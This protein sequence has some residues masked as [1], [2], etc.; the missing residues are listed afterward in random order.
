MRFLD[1]TEILACI[2]PIPDAGAFP[3]SNPGNGAQS[4]FDERFALESLF[5][6][7]PPSSFLID[8]FAY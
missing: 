2:E 6:F 5:E 3:G 4:M 8:K 7:T 1:N